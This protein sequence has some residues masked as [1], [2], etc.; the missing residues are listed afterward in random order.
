MLCLIYTHNTQGHSAPEGECVNRIREIISESNIWQFALNMQLA[1]SFEYCVEE[2]HA[3]SLNG[4]H[5]I[6][7]YLHDLPNRQIKVIANYNTYTV[8]QAKH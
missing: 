1:G 5:L 2:T 7:Q 8:Y 4:V 6:W 3:Y